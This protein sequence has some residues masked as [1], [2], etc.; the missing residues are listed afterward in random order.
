MPVKTEKK[1]SKKTE[2]KRTRKTAAKKTA[3]KKTGKKKST[4]KE[5]PVVRAF[6]IDRGTWLRGNVKNLFGSDA[7]SKLCDVKGRKCCLG[8]YLE[9]VGVKALVGKAD[10]SDLSRIPKESHW[11]VEKIPSGIKYAGRSYFNSSQC[12]ALVEAND[13]YRSTPK[14]RESEVKALFKEQ[15]ISVTFRGKTPLKPSKKSSKLD[16]QQG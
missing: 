11:L 4:R 6:T 3:A 15:G 14:A 7:E 2:K 12:S 16:E 1:R 8:F 13:G 9:A 10:P 5:K